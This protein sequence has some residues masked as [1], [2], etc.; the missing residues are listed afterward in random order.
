MTVKSCF[1]K[2]RN[3][4]GF[5][6]IELLVVIAIIG[7]L[8]ALLLPAVQAAR[9]SARRMQC[10]NNIKQVALAALNHV[11]VHKRLPLGCQD[12][13][14][15]LSGPWSPPRQSWL[16]Y[17]LPFLEEQN[18]LSQYDF[19]LGMGANG[20][21]TG[22]VNYGTTNSATP[23]SPTSFVPSVFL[24]PTDTGM[25][26]VQTP[27][28]YYGLGNYLV[29]F[30]GLTLGGAN[31]SNLQ[32]NQRGA[33]GIN[34]GARPKDFMD[35]TSHTLA[36]GEYL[37]STGQVV[38]G[39]PEQRGMLWQ[40]DEPGGGCL[41]TAMTPNSTTPDVFDSIWWCFNAPLQPCVT[42]SGS[43]SD[44]T[45]T[46]RSRH[47]GGVLVALADGSVQFVDESIDLAA[48][49]AMCTISGGEMNVVQ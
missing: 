23:T 29:F 41:M 3:P 21:Y 20:I 10:G 1:T 32:N 47:P 33:F 34:F 16:P 48:W 35:G 6:L 40:S 36:F 8:I 17:L 5:T 49:Q 39:S 31:P 19:K 13:V 22:L 18:S 24:C 43:G 12:Q 11:D 7:I 37:R 44:H 26:Q 15:A 46:A 25:L 4:Q 30:G 42:G 9:D 38:A 28:G 14:P 45:A 27:A 2:R